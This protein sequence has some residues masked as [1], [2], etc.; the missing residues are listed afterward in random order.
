MGGARA[1]PVVAERA[2]ELSLRALGLL[3]SPRR[4]SAANAIRHGEQR[5]LYIAFAVFAL[6]F[7]LGLFGLMVWLL[8]EF[9]EIGG[10]GPVLARKFLDILVSSLFSL[11]VFSNV[12]TALSVYFLSA[13][14]ELVLALPLSRP[15]FHYAR[16]ADTLIQS[17]WMMLLF[18]LPVFAAAGWMAGSDWTYFAMILVTVP[19]ML[20]IATSIGVT[21]ATVVANLVSAQ[22]TRDLMLIIAAIMLGIAFIVLRGLRPEQLA[23]AEAFQTLAE[24]LAA[25]ELPTPRLFPAR[26]AAEVLGASLLGSP[27]PWTE[28]ALLVLGAGAGLAVSRWV[29]RA[30]F[31]SGWVSAQEARTARFRDQPIFDHLTLVLP[32]AWRPVAAKELRVL[33]RDPSQWSQVFLL[34]GLCGVYLA[35]IQALP[36]DVFRGEAGQWLRDAITFLNLG[37]GGFVMAA[38]AGRF[39]FTAISREGKAWW[40]LRSAPVDPLVVLRAKTAFGLVPMLVVG[41]VVTVGGGWLLHARLPLLVGEAF[42]VVVLAWGISGLAAAMGA[43]WPDF[44]AENA[45]R[46]AS[47]PAAVFFMV[48][49]MVLVFGVM[50]AFV[51]AAFLAFKG[52]LWAAPVLGLVAVAMCV[53]AGHVPP[54]RAAD[55]LW[56]EGLK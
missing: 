52:Y 31:D 30:L 7:W 34:V 8:G 21:V 2:P 20:V 16:L 23:D 24:Y 41:E 22:R 36:I 27:L 53:W 14:L 33:V 40:V 9:W 3:L 5:W 32:R 4:L 12:I 1:E 37:M 25:V 35:S 49:A 11:L 26:W 29:G 17:S 43:L 39:Q 19:A 6:A 55:R 28:L 54:R 15:T 48:L 47:S 50:S 38:I 56:A 10:L 46:A 13:D 51:L 44:N 45:A 18:G 42:M